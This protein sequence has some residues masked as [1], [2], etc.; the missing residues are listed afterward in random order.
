LKTSGSSGSNARK[1]S[2]IAKYAP[3]P[4]ISGGSPTVVA[5]TFDLGVEQADEA[6]AIVTGFLGSTP[7]IRPLPLPVSG[8]SVVTEAK[9]RVTH[10]SPSTP[11][12]DLYLVADGTNLN[13]AAVT[14]AFRAVSFGTD[15]GILS[16]APGVYDVYVTPAGDKGTVAINVQNFTLTGG[17]VLDVIARDPAGNGSEGTLPQ[18][19]VVN[20]ETITACT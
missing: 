14:P 10:G 12:V 7:A 1:A 18:L 20:H 13:D 16:I 5:L 15:T 4:Y 3:I 6:M 19:I 9:L 8:R 2:R 11:A 17:E